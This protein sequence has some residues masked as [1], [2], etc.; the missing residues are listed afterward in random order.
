LACEE[1]DIISQILKEKAVNQSPL[2]QSLAPGESRESKT[3]FWELN[4][5]CSMS[6][7]CFVLQ[8]RER[9]C[10]DTVHVLS[11]EQLDILPGEE[12]S[13]KRSS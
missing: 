12:I 11:K 8:P 10:C 3:G 7:T 4:I 6:R 5:S 9:I 2:G 1:Y 13:M